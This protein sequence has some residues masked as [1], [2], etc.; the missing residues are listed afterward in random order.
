MIPSCNFLINVGIAPLVG[1][2][3]EDNDVIVLRLGAPTSIRVKLIIEGEE[4]VTTTT[5]WK[6]RLSHNWF[7]FGPS[8]GLEVEGV[9]VAESDAG[10]VQTAMATIDV[11]FAI[12]VA[13]CSVCSRCWCTDSRLL[14][15][16]DILVTEYASPSVITNLEE[17]TVV[18]S[19]GWAS[20]TTEN[21][22]AVEFG[23]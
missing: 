3:V 10:V 8:L 2:E 18:K 22:D 5:F 13:G 23:S 4:R 9:N 1:V 11:Y 21:E 19:L 16:V 7:M 6:R 12:I 20:M 17:P 15:G 14:I